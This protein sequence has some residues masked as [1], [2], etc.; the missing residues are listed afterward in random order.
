MGIKRKRWREK[1]ALFERL[2]EWA[3]EYGFL[4]DGDF[5]DFEGGRKGDFIA[6]LDNVFADWDKNTKTR[7]GKLE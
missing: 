1:N 4:L 6:S 3:E 5:V 7:E 2:V